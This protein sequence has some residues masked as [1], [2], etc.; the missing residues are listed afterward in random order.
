[1]AKQERIIER[2]K[3]KIKAWVKILI[4]CVIAGAVVFLLKAP[5]FNV[6]NYDIQGNHY[7][8]DDEIFAMGNCQTGG[9]IFIGTDLADIKHRLEKDAYMKEVNVKRKL[10]NT[11]VIE[12]TERK[13]TAALVYGEKYVVVDG[14]GIVLRK[15][16]VEPELTIISGLTIT[17]L[18]MGEQVEAEQGTLLKKT[19]RI[20]DCMEDYGMY[21]VSIELKKG[22]IKA[23]IL[24]NL[25]CKGTPE[26][27][28]ESIKTNNLQLVVQE[29]FEK[30]IER[31]TIEVSGESYISFNPK[32]S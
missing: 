5:Q 24:K 14:D 12:L 31:G 8:N 16:S 4:V 10:P 25:I 30:E 3:R 26:N 23:H 22:E 15:T 32:V 27:I 13:Q 6:E 29:L 20:L 18:T 28:I 2:R 9:N 1:M 19:L 17:K 7:Y 11:I 21:F